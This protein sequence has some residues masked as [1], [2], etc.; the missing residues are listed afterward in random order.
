MKQYDLLKFRNALVNEFEKQR[1]VVKA[2]TDS[3]GTVDKKNLISVVR[4]ATM[5]AV[6]SDLID[7]LDENGFSKDIL[8]KLDFDVIETISEVVIPKKKK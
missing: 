2:L 3:N 7:L 8:M 1:A 4:S 6:Y 5:F